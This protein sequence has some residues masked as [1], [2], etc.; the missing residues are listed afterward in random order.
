MERYIQLRVLT[1]F[2]LF[3]L[4][5]IL[6]KSS[7]IGINL[8]EERVSNLASVMGCIVG[9]FLFKYLAYPLM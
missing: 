6:G 4:K 5:M 9:K 1:L 7:M 2:E 3:V 8:S